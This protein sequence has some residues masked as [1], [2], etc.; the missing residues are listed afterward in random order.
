MNFKFSV[1]ACFNPT[2][3]DRTLEFNG[4]GKKLEVFHAVTYS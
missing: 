3:I 4:E 2:F 1:M